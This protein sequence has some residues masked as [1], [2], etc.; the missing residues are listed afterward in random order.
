MDEEHG[1]VGAEGQVSKRAPW[2]GGGAQLVP[3]TSP[4]RE[5]GGLP[6]EATWRLV[7]NSYVGN[8]FGN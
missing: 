4:A 6:A 8:G 3:P 1:L 5:D 7:P 2:S